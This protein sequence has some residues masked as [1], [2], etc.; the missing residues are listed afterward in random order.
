MYSMYIER[1]AIVS[2]CNTK[3]IITD[4]FDIRS[5]IN[6]EIIG[7]NYTNRQTQAV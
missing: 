4:I 5:Y 2:L 1:G 6:T 3:L 7:K